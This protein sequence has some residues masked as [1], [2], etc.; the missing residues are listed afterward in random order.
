MAW[1]NRSGRSSGVISLIQKNS[2]KFV[3]MRSN[4]DKNIKNVIF[5]FF[6]RFFK[7]IN[8]RHFLLIAVPTAPPLN[9]RFTKRRKRKLEGSWNKPDTRRRR[10]GNATRDIKFVILHGTIVVQKHGNKLSSCNLDPLF[11]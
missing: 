5:I 4:I 7:F 8:A 1:F 10:S 2:F 6:D 9:V 3:H 11:Q